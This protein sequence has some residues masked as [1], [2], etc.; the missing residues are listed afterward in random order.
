MDF[1]SCGTCSVPCDAFASPFL[2]S[3]RHSISHSYDPQQFFSQW[4]T[5]G[6]AFSSFLSL[7]ITDMTKQDPCYGRLFFSR[8]VLDIQEWIQRMSILP[9]RTDSITNIEPTRKR[10]KT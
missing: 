9:E 2:C 5:H 7:A 1:V 4:L 10:L 6:H 3:N 8:Q